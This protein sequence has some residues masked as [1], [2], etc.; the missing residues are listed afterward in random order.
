M[1]V[2]KAQTEKEYIQCFEVLK[3]LRP[4][5]ILENYLRQIAVMKAE[6]YQLIYIEHHGVALS[7]CGFRPLNTLYDGPILYIDDL[8]T[9]PTEQGKGYGG[10]LFDYVVDEAKTTGKKAVHLDS[11]HHRYDAHKFYLN[12][13]MKI[14]YHHF[15]LEL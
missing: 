8:V 11:G 10:K 12:K 1:T 3:V 7:A 13:K 6:K 2:K 4:H 15:R 9:L 14:V 5:L